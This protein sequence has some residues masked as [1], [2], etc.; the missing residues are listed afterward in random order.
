[1]SEGVETKLR[2]VL[3]A[4]VAGFSKSMELAEEET[5]TQF[6]DLMREIVEP[7]ISGHQG[8]VV[9]TLGDGFFSEFGGCAAAVRCAA[10]IQ[11]AVSSSGFSLRLRIGINFGEL[12]VDEHGDLHGD[13]VIVAFRLESQAPP[14]GILIS[15]KVFAE[16]KQKQDLQ[17]RAQGKLQV[18]NRENPVE[19]YLV[20]RKNES[21]S[22]RPISPRGVKLWSMHRFTA[23]V[24]LLIFLGTAASAV[25]TFWPAT[26]Q[27]RLAWA[28]MEGDVQTNL[29]PGQKIDP[30]HFDAR[31]I[32]GAP[33]NAV[34]SYDVKNSCDWV[35]IS[36]TTING[37]L[38][39][40]LQA[41]LRT[42]SVVVAAVAT[43]NGRVLA[44]LPNRIIKLLPRDRKIRDL[45]VGAFHACA[46]LSTEDVSCWIK[47]SKHGDISIARNLLV[48]SNLKATVIAAGTYD[49]CA[50]DRTY[51]YYCWGDVHEER[52]LPLKLGSLGP[53][54]TLLAGGRSV[55]VRNDAG[56]TMCWGNGN[57]D[58][59]SFDPKSAI[60]TFDGRVICA[61][62]N[63]SLLCS[64]VGIGEPIFDLGKYTGR[65]STFSEPN[66][67]RV[68]VVIDGARVV[69]ARSNGDDVE[70]TSQLP[71]GSIDQVID[72][73]EYICVHYTTGGA[74]CVYPKEFRSMYAGAGQA[75]VIP[76]D[77]RFVKLAAGKFYGICAILDSDG[78]R[79][80]GTGNI[81]E[82]LEVPEL[83]R[84]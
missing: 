72:N 74:T 35:S 50:I 34:I 48:P 38:P 43:A 13:G 59:F 39:F 19:A 73:S 9:K 17:F 20:S 47:R 40:S 12:I 11:D 80:W 70:I 16:I 62:R 51:S 64:R 83:L 22:S 1:M 25:W 41:L 3:A 2:V 61:L 71:R 7:L 82:G 65:I 18:K 8:R 29:V 84:G 57:T 30:V 21:D 67:E 78:V 60:N 44:T 28:S 5:Y 63:G 68:C 53:K 37:E 69:C 46:L 6:A 27:A 49:T 32:D 45:T 4:D 14:G 10:E 79:C 54:S 31:F 56:L 15:E 75:P 24:S 26:R 52:T 55:C 33:E 58:R 77:A 36:N 66:L 23:A 42:C 76:S 81:D